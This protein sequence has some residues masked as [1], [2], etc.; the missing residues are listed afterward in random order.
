MN[1]YVITKDQVKD[2]VYV[3]S[4]DLSIIDGHLQVEADLGWFRVTGS[5]IAKGSIFIKAGSSIE[6]GSS[7][8]AGWG[9]ACKTLLSWK[10][11]LFAGVCWWRKSTDKDKQIICG[12]AEGG[13]VEYGILTQTG[14]LGEEDHPQEE[15]PV[16]SDD[17]AIIGG[18]RFKLV[19]ESVQTTKD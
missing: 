3:G 5:V 16:A 15:T 10:W 12:K 2:G 8:K 6:A 11:Q 13:T 17:Y 4:Q 7:I 19:K 18:Q 9:I 14:L 1:T